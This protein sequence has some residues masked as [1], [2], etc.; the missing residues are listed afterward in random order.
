M[1][2][3]AAAAENMRPSLRSLFEQIVSINLCCNLQPGRTGGRLVFEGLTEECI[4]ILK[5][6]YILFP[7]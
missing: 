1:E 4:V 2:K 6:M 3:T 5:L 7:G